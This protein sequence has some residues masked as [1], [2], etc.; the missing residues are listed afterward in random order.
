MV[1]SSIAFGMLHM[2]S[3]QPSEWIGVI[4][5]TYFGIAMGILFLRSRRNLLLPA[6]FHIVSNTTT[7]LANA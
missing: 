6:G 2:S 5:H 1:V 7:F 3:L 4:P